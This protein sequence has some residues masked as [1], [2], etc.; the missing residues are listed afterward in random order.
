MFHASCQAWGNHCNFPLC[1]AFPHVLSHSKA[2]VL[3]F[4]YLLNDTGIPW[5]IM[6]GFLEKD[7]SN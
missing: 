4:E 1:K 6:D 5:T 2:A 3:N 7:I